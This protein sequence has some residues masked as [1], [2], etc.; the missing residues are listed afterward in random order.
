VPQHPSP[1]GLRREQPIEKAA[2]LLRDGA[3]TP[4]RSARVYDVEGDAGTYQVI[5]GPNG[6][7][8]HCPARTSLCPH[9]LAV[10]MLEHPAA[11][12]QTELFAEPE[13]PFV[14]FDRLAAADALGAL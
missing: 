14:R 1:T 3:V 13:D 11:G 12:E 5:T 7:I 6:T 2:R 8:C 9:V 10:I 4:S